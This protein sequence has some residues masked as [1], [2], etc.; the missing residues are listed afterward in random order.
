MVKN[1]VEGEKITSNVV[2]WHEKCFLYNLNSGF[3]HYSCTYSS[4]GI[5]TSD[6]ASTSDTKANVPVPVPGVDDGKKTNADADTVAG[7]NPP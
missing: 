7:I 6:G 3:P 4:D 5:N 2:S 1:N